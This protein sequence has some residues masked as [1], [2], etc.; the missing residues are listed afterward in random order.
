MVGDNVNPNKSRFT[1]VELPGLEKLSDDPSELR[2][3]E[4]P[5]SKALIALNSTVTSLAQNPYP[6]RVITYRYWN[7]IIFY[8]LQVLELDDLCSGASI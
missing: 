8:D 2:Q 7:M 4:G 3:R 5:T 6:D 1:I